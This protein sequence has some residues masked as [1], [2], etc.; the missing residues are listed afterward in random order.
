[1]GVA[2]L[3]RYNP[4]GAGAG[5]ASQGLPCFLTQGQVFILI[6]RQCAGHATEPRT[7]MQTRQTNSLV[8]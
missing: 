2:P 5:E 8:T 6:Q 4:E 7:K 3:S 1:M